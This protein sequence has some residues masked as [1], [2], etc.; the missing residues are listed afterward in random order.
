[1][2][3]IDRMSRIDKMIGYLESVIAAGMDSAVI[4]DPP[5]MLKWLKELKRLRKREAKK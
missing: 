5:A 2:S 1:M 4:T 3:R